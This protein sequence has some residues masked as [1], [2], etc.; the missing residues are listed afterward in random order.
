MK[1]CQ[2]I[3]RLSTCHS[4]VMQ[5]ANLFILIIYMRDCSILSTQL[6]IY[7]SDYVVSIS[8]SFLYSGNL[9]LNKNTYSN[10][11]YIIINQKKVSELLQEV[12]Q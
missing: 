7:A 10:H 4:N 8:F 12:W 6:C 9:S 2:V 3:Y 11:T 1:M 5:R